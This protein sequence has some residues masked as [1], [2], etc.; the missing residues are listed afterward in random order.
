M[1]IKRG[2][3]SRARERRESAISLASKSR[4]YAAAGLMLNVSVG[5]SPL[6]EKDKQ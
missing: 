6:S 2:M 4:F 3:M 5:S 1:D